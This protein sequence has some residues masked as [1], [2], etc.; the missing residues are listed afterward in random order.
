[1]RTGQLIFQR[2]KQRRICYEGH[3]LSR[4]LDYQPIWSALINQYF[5]GDCGMEQ[6]VELFQHLQEMDEALADWERYRTNITEEA[7]NTNRDTR[8]MVMFATLTNDFVLWHAMLISIQS[9]LDIANHLIVR[10]N[11]RRPAT[12]REAFEILTEASVI[13]QELSEE[14]A[15]L[16]G[17]RNILVHVYWR[18][19]LHR[20]YEI[21]QYG[22]TPLRQ[23]R[24]ITSQLLAQQDEG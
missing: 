19:D 24:N 16:A 1:M 7:I 14:L 9:C 21:L 2:E 22:L 4:Y 17:F 13:P 20:V 10:E 8:N 15:D 23:F 12:Y 3:I 11:L 18:L 5:K 6:Q